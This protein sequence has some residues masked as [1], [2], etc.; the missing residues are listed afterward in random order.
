[1]NA[2]SFLEMQN[3]NTKARRCIDLVTLFANTT[4]GVEVTIDVV[5]T[6]NTMFNSTRKTNKWK[7]RCCTTT[8]E[9]W[10]A[11]QTARKITTSSQSMKVTFQTLIPNGRQ[12]LTRQTGTGIR[13]RRRLCVFIVMG[14]MARAVGDA[15]GPRSGSRRGRNGLRSSSG[16][17]RF[18]G[19]ARSF[20]NWDASER[21]H[22]QNVSISTLDAF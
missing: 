15:N 14:L 11:S 19:R 16:C 10:H 18:E 22:R 17:D 2:E 7:V 12:K 20:G 21:V 5:F 13:N 4:S 8:I 1:M 3:S 9:S 6:F